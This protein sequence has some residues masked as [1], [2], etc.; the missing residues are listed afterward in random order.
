[1][2]GSWAT[3]PVKTGAKE[4]GYRRVAMHPVLVVH[5]VLMQCCRFT[6]LLKCNSADC[7]RVNLG[8]VWR[9]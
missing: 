9:P 8:P 3:L 2:D 6:A 7:C 1:M 4:P 5:L